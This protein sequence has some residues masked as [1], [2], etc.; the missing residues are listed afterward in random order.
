VRKFREGVLVVG[1]GSRREEANADVREVAKSIGQ[2]GG[3]PLVVAAFLEIAIPDIDQGLGQLI[4]AGANHII[5]HPY[6]LSPGRH[7]RGDIPAK[8]ATA[9]NRHSHLSYQITEPLA[10]HPFVID[11]SIERIRKT[12]ARRSVEFLGSKPIGPGK[13]YLVGAG[14]GDPGL[15]T[16]KLWNCCVVPM[17]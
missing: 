5:V 11:A 15:I 14:P 2:R 7:T 8:V 3:F 16:V 12:Q 17:S 13:V 4:E 10:A 1:H 9:V 6:F